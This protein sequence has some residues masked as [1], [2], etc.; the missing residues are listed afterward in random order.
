[1]SKVVELLKEKGIVDRMQKWVDKTITLYPE[2]VSQSEIDEAV[3]GIF[4]LEMSR[5]GDI[6]DAFAEYSYDLAMDRI[7]KELGIKYNP[8][9]DASKK[10]SNKD[11]AIFT[12]A[13]MLCR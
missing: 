1:M 4:G 12:L 2:G 11:R 9:S 13:V 3:R 6:E 10:I 7:V 5:D 8:D